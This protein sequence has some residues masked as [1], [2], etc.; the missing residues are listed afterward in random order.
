MF[1]LLP[2]I[3]KTAPSGGFFRLS[4]AL[5]ANFSAGNDEYV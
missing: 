5:L 4:F 3:Q 2:K 1:A